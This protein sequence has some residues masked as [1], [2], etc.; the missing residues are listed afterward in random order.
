MNSG[1]SDT[2]RKVLMDC[3]YATIEVT[4]PTNFVQ[5]IPVA[6]IVLCPDVITKA[7]FHVVM[8]T[9]GARESFGRAIANYI[10]HQTFTSPPN[11]K[12]R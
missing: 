1:L 11:T 9:D 3:G 12:G 5:S 7:L 2:D 8:T 10:D 4:D 6:P